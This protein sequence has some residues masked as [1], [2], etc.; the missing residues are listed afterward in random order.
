MQA[1]TT[2]TDVT[3]ARDALRFGRQVAAVELVAT[4]T[5]PGRPLALVGVGVAVAVTANTILLGAS[6]LPALLALVGTALGWLALVWLLTCCAEARACRRAAATWRYENASG[7]TAVALRTADRPTSGWLLQSMAARPRGSGA[8]SQLIRGIC[9]QADAAGAVIA[10]V[11]VTN[12]AA[13]WYTR[14]GFQRVRK[15]LPLGQWRLERQP[16]QPPLRGGATCKVP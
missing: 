8:G 9:A 11:A 5:D 15:T 2:T 12:R 4:V 10:L 1:F 7:A 16:E 13:D 3:S 6:W 14:F